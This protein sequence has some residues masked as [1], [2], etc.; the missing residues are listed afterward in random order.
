MQKPKKKNTG[1]IFLI[2]LLEKSKNKL[3]QTSR[4]SCEEFSKKLR[5][6]LK[7][8]LRLKLKEKSRKEFMNKSWIGTTSGETL[9]GILERNPNNFPFPNKSVNKSQKETLIT[10]RVLE[11]FS[12]F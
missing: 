11:I 9:R 2:K 5:K 12:F 8:E 7:K 10:E 4:K 1:W 6:N 3:Q